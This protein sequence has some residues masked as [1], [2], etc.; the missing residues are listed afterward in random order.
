LNEELV[1]A[2]D[3]RDRPKFAGAPQKARLN[4]AIAYVDTNV[5]VDFVADAFLRVSHSPASGLVLPAGKRR[6][7]H[8]LPP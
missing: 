6:T 7:L 5:E 1:G 4:G 3:A 2:R 8:L